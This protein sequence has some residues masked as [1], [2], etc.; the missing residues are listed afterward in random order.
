MTDDGEDPIDLAQPRAKT[1][2]G[3]GTI[4]F[5]KDGVAIG[6]PMQ[7]ESLEISPTTR[8]ERQPLEPGMICVIDDPWVHMQSR[9]IAAL[10]AKG[11]KVVVLD[12]GMVVGMDAL[13]GSMKSAAEAMDKLSQVMQRNRAALEPTPFYSKPRKEKAQWKR[14][15]HKGRK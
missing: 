2:I 12:R 4:T 9:L 7:C 5:M 3:R 8:K 6:E 14:E 15:Q 1:F 11:H 13:G 10:V